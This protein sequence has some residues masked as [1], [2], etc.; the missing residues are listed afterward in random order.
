MPA[1]SICLAAPNTKFKP[2]PVRIFQHKTLSERKESVWDWRTVLV[3]LQA[4]L[5]E[6]DKKVRE[7]IRRRNREDRLLFV[8]LLCVV[9]F[10]LWFL[11][12]KMI[13]WASNCKHSTRVCPNVS[14]LKYKSGTKWKMLRGIY[15]AIHGEVNVSVCFEIKGEYTGWTQK[16]SLISSSYNIKTYWNILTKLVATVP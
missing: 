12:T 3:L 6:M 11:V 8:A 13:F 15:S 5:E 4:K 1:F 9:L 16:H 10:V 14:G 2:H 7:A